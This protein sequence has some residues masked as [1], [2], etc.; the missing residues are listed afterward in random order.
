M[1]DACLGVRRPTPRNMLFAARKR[2]AVAFESIARFRRPLGG[3]MTSPTA[4][5]TG[6]RRRRCGSKSTR[7]LSRST[8]SG[9][10]NALQCTSMRTHFSMSIQ[11][12]VTERTQRL[13]SS[14]TQR[15]IRSFRHGIFQWSVQLSDH[16][17]SVR[18]ERSTRSC[19]PK[20]RPNVGL[21]AQTA[22]RLF[23]QPVG[24]P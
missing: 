17:I 7:P 14:P 10:G 4:F 15:E 13:Y 21:H 19:R 11:S 2:F 1:G 23:P 18:I 22:R 9:L 12:S 16:G 8:A 3:H 24:W 20:R 5:P 6:R